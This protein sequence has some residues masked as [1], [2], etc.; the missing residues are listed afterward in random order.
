MQF[1]TY[2]TWHISRHF[3]SRFRGDD[4]VVDLLDKHGAVRVSIPW[5]KYKKTGRAAAKARGLT[6]RVRSLNVYYDGPKHPLDADKNSSAGHPIY[7]GDDI[8]V[9]VFD[10]T[11][12]LVVTIP[13]RNYL[14]VQ[15][16]IQQQGFTIREYSI[17]DPPPALTH[18]PTALTTP[19]A[20]QPCSSEELSEDNTSVVDVYTKREVF[21]TRIPMT[22]YRHFKAY[23]SEFGLKTRIQNPALVPEPLEYEDAAERSNTDGPYSTAASLG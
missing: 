12:T 18:S 1:K 9:D 11:G 5:S 6:T 7:N 23:I 21:L 22:R 10:G 3:Q 17:Y 13:R 16:L 14:R 19:I 2:L 8:V 4:K 15:T 20:Q